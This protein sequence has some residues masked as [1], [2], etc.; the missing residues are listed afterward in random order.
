MADEPRASFAGRFSFSV[1]GIEVGRFSEVSGL[2]VEQQVE[3]V[4]EGGHP[5]TH[6][7]PVRL[8]HPN[9][10]LKRGVTNDDALLRWL[11]ETRDAID[12]GE[13]LER[14]TGKVQLIDPKGETVHEWSFEG[15]FPVRWAGPTLAVSASDAARE[16][17]E[18]SHAGFW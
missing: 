3:E 12:R 10:V 2:Q 11:R 13:K 17:L 15:A 7:L 1:D 9:L 4:A 14:R 5:G 16:E 18:I 8:S 6:R